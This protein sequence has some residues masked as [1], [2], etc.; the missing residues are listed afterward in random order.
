MGKI[1]TDLHRSQPQTIKLIKRMGLKPKHRGSRS[2]HADLQIH[3]YYSDG[4]FSPTELAIAANFLGLKAI[5]LTDHDTKAGI[6]EME[7]ACASFGI[8]FIPAIELTTISEMWHMWHILGYHMRFRDPVLLRRLNEINEAKTENIKRAL[9]NLDQYGIKLSET[10]IMRIFPRGA[11]SITHLAEVLRVNNHAQNLISGINLIRDL[12]QD[13][14]SKVDVPYFSIPEAIR[15]I[16]ADGGIPIWAHPG[17]HENREV[18]FNHTIERNLWGKNGLMGF[19]FV[20]GRCSEKITCSLLLMI[21]KL[22]ETGINPIL[23]VASDYHDGR[24]EV[25][26]GVGLPWEVGRAD[27]ILPQLNAA[28]ENKSSIIITP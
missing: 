19:E 10:D 7:E 6:K 16:H 15:L 11:A 2:E 13:H 18:F 8:E 28:R 25:L 4:F 14:K 21:D 26:G 12:Y 17:R 5:A 9:H 23:T 1:I 27:D 3:S 24:R 20:H 22:R